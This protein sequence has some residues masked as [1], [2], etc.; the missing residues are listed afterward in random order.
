[1]I[2]AHFVVLVIG[3]VQVHEH[4]PGA[5]LRVAFSADPE[6]L[7]LLRRAGASADEPLEAERLLRRLCEWPSDAGSNGGG[8]GA[9]MR[10]FLQQ[11]RF[12]QVRV[13]DESASLESA[14]ADSAQF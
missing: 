6:A 11:N 1:M 7:A 14:L 13:E 3:V 2:D 9:A 8:C 12:R 5:A 10:A 4:G